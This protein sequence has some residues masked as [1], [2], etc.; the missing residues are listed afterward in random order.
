MI[1]LI[2]S[3]IWVKPLMALALTAVIFGAGTWTGWKWN[4]ISFQS[5]K[6]QVAEEKLVQQKALLRAIEEA[7]ARTAA[8]ESASAEAIARLKMRVVTITKEVTR[9]VEKPVYRCELPDTGR[10]LLDDAVREA[11]T[12]IKASGKVQ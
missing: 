9:E 8:V 2:G 6:T 12:A 4:S 5:Y 7:N 10:V 3:S 11:N 1:P